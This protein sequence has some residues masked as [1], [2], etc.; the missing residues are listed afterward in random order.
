[1]NDDEIWISWYPPF[2]FKS[3]LKS[4]TPESTKIPLRLG[5]ICPFRNL[6]VLLFQVAR[7]E[8]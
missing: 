2:I 3:L 8:L 1:M 5:L 6:S 7:A 4:L